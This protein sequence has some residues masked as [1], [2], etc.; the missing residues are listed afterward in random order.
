MCPAGCLGS[1]VQ[2]YP[3]GADLSS[4]KRGV[5]F[6]G[7]SG[8]N[9][10]T[11]HDSQENATVAIETARKFVERLENEPAL[12]WQLYVANPK[13]MTKFRQFVQG[14]G[15][16]VSEE[17]LTVALAASTSP[18]LERLRARMLPASTR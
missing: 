15:F 1:D 2:V 6:R 14:K 10:A 17:E 13:G 16:V 5:C 11:S 12:R 18:S 4:I 9:H 7:V 3:S 8:Y